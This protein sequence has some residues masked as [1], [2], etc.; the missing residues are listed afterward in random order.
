MFHGSPLIE[1]RRLRKENN[2]SL[3]KA[4][5]V[6]TCFFNILVES[7]QNEITREMYLVCRA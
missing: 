6:P 3:D 4:A 2:C 5:V 1:I 7:L